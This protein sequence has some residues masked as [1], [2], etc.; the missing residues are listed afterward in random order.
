LTKKWSPLEIQEC[1]IWQGNICRE[2][3]TSLWLMINS[4]T[5]PIFVKNGMN[6][7]FQYY[8][9]LTPMDF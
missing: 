1:D 3:C 6:D 4:H 8:R 2:R 5:T 9:R 7:H